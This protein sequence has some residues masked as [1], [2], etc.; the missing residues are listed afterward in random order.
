[1]SYIVQ[2]AVVLISLCLCW[3]SCVLLTVCI[4][5]ELNFG[6]VMVTV[7]RISVYMGSSTH[8]T[9][10]LNCKKALVSGLNI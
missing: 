6:P 10:T 5:S 3:M 7:D 9:R 8:R 1:M 2:A 4:F